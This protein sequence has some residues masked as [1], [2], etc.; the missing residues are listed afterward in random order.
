MCIRDRYTLSYEKH[1][2]S[3]SNSQQDVI[4]TGR[5]C[6]QRSVHFM[7]LHSNCRVHGQ[8]S[9]P[10]SNWLQRLTMDS[11]MIAP[12]PESP[13]G[14]I[15]H[16]AHNRT[17]YLQRPRRE[18]SAMIRESMERPSVAVSSYPHKA[19]SVVVWSSLMMHRGCIIS[20]K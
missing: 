13:P 1:P 2:W 14:A 3:C 15:R 9:G 11:L 8:R 20:A 5:P 7:S 17:V 12:G 10:G 19:F 4:S 6:K 16:E 18:R